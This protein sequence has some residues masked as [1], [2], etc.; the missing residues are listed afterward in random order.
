MMN[1]KLSIMA[2][3]IVDDFRRDGVTYSSIEV[4]SCHSPLILI[5]LTPGTTPAVSGA[6]TV[7]I[8][9]SGDNTTT[10]TFDMAYRSTNIVR[11]FKLDITD[12]IRK[13]CDEA[14]LELEV[15]PP[16]L[17]F[18]GSRRATEIEIVAKADGEGDQT[19]TNWYMHGFNQVN[20][21]DSSCLVDFVDEE[22]EARMCIAPG[23]PMMFHLWNTET[24]GSTYFFDVKKD[25]GAVRGV[26]MGTDPDIGL[27]QFYDPI[28][29][30]EFYD[31][32]TGKQDEFSIALRKVG[33]GD[34]ASMECFSPVRACEG[35]VVLAWL[36]RYGIYSYMAFDKH[37]TQ[38]RNQKHIGSYDFEFYDIADLQSRQKSRGYSGVHTVISAIASAVDTRYFD[39][40]EDLFYSMDVYYFTGT[41]PEYEFD[42][43][44]WLR[45]KVSGSLP[46]RKKHNHENVRVDIMLPEKYT[47]LR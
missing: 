3:E 17:L 35:S 2:I 41:L 32:D 8:T 6:V 36:N 4:I 30:L 23:A 31:E 25:G 39:A 5:V 33:V 26:S 12:I 42:P 34:S 15:T 18:E 37:Y 27:I 46:E 22:T 20:N 29:N 13:I 21:P 7:E 10:Y 40:I 28:N 9:G 38:V 1:K 19:V 24:S 11:L 44:E 16:A 43:T 45:V 14:Q 47:Q